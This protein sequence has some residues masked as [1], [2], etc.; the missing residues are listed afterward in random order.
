MIRF[1]GKAEAPRKMEMRTS[2][3]RPATRIPSAA[4]R[5]WNPTLRTPAACAPCACP[6]PHAPPSRPPYPKMRLLQ[7]NTNLV[8]AIQNFQSIP[9]NAGHKTN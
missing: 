7:R 4:Q 2:N 8:S 5:G 6:V 3:K 9:R 1:T